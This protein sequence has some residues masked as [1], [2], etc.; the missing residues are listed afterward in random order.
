MSDSGANL[1]SEQLLLA[2]SEKII[3]PNLTVVNS[4]GATLAAARLQKDW[5]IQQVAEQLKLSPRQIVALEANQFEILPKMVIV[6][7][8]VRAYSKLL[9]IDADSVVALLPKDTDSTQLEAALKPA[10]STPFLESRLSLMGRQENNHRYMI[11]AALLAVFAVVFFLLQRTE[12]VGSAKDWMGRNSASAPDSIVSAD[13]APNAVENA[14]PAPASSAETAQVGS[15]IADS[16]AIGMNAAKNQVIQE[17]PKTLP[18]GPSNATPDGIV[19][20]ENV[21]AA[22]PAVQAASLLAATKDVVKFKFRQDSWIQIKKENGSILT[23]HLAKAGTEEVVEVKET[24]QVRMGN[25]AGVV[26]ELR[27]SP[28]EVTP[29]K[30][31]N[32]VNLIIK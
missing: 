10:L 5:S 11:G 25:A 15:V 21:L 24:L 3:K 2:E 4:V 32:V 7:G 28:L 14:I 13:S 17:Q 27:G 16:A 23:S 29:E 31:S 19:N 22:A 20:A 26:A 12:I 6:R 9:K 18:G 8:F 1:L 30:G